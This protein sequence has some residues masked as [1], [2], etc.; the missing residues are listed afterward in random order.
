ME[1]IRDLKHIEPV[2]ESVLSIGS[3]DGVHLAHQ[4]ILRRLCRSGREHNRLRTIVTF[5]PHPQ[6]VV[7]PR[8]QAPLLLTDAV[9]KTALLTAA[10]VERLVVLPFDRE[11]AALDAE[12]FLREILLER[13]GMT[14]M[15]IGYN[16]AFGRGRSGNRETLAALSERYGFQLDVV[17]PILV[18]EVRISST[19]V[20]R[21]LLAGDLDGATAMLGRAHFFTGNVVG[22]A[23]RGRELG[24]PTLNLKI[25][26]ERKLLPP[27]GVYATRALVEDRRYVGLLNLGPA[28][29]FDRQREI[30]ELHLFGYRGGTVRTLQVE[31]IQWL[32][33]IRR[34][35]DTDELITQLRQ[36]RLQAVDIAR[37][38]LTEPVEDFE[39]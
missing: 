5:Q 19:Q 18:D 38:S 17:Q 2:A 8:D 35:R 14:E 16:H 29:T 34:F 6:T 33:P 3:F 22:G 25:E 1:I 11:L 37:D 4:E 27:S 32:R 39:C 10:G 24:F 23:G 7:G 36:D 9:E 21:R 20:R 12:T 31:F 30:P 28:P 26:E 15:V 13:I